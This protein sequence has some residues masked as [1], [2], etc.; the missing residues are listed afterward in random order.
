MNS[1]FD[2]CTND[3]NDIK[4]LGNTITPPKDITSQEDAAA[5]LYVLSSIVSKRLKKHG[6]KALCVSIVIRRNDF[7]IITRQKSFTH[8]TDE[9]DAIFGYAY[10]L[11]TKNH[12]WERSV[13]S[14]GVRADKLSRCETE[15]LSLL[16]CFE[17]PEKIN[18]NISELIAKIKEE[19]GSFGLEQSASSRDAEISI[20]E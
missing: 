4:S 20:M 12:T 1:S 10:E 19:Y 7:S 11:F 9:E 3:E 6:F 13:R 17:N 2:P 14:I 5:F 18:K 16:D 15:Q 8:A